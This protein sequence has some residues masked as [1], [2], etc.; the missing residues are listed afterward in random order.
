MELSRYSRDHS[1]TAHG[2]EQLLIQAFTKA[3][4]VIPRT[5][6]YNARFDSTDF[7]N[8]F[9]SKNAAPDGKWFGANIEEAGIWDTWSSFV[10]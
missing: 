2:K 5:L 1:L 10:C 3:S 7:L 9:R 4:E 8:K 6:C